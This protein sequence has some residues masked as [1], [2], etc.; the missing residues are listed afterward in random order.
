[1]NPVLMAFDI[2]ETALSFLKQRSSIS[3]KFSSRVRF[4]VES[5]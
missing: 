1:V 4:K 3:Q 2:F 5:G